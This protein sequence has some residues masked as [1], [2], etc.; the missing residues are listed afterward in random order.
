MPETLVLNWVSGVDDRAARLP[1][2]LRLRIAHTISQHIIARI[3]KVV[4]PILDRTLLIVLDQSSAAHAEPPNARANTI[5]KPKPE[6]GEDTAREKPPPKSRHTT[7]QVIL[8]SAESV[9][10]AWRPA[11]ITTNT[12]IKT[13]LGSSEDTGRKKLPPKSK[14]TAV[15]AMLYSVESVHHPLADEVLFELAALV[16][17]DAV[18]PPV[19]IP[20]F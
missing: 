19:E 3:E 12:I 7:V 16:L 13:Q 15:Q 14:H 9:H 10:H 20:A 8:Y 2:K 11:G 5:I 4:I 6:S 18:V 17:V 1:T